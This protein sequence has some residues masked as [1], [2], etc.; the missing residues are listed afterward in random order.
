MGDGSKQARSKHPEF[1]PTHKDF[2]RPLSLRPEEHFTDFRMRFPGIT[3]PW[4]E[5]L[6]LG[7][8]PLKTS[9]KKHSEMFSEISEMFVLSSKIFL[10]GGV[11][12]VA[13]TSLRIC[14][15]TI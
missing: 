5:K 6:D 12:K 11:H 8:K 1:T 9:S 13:D 3:V 14:T 15:I 4:C 7:Y 2:V 10:W